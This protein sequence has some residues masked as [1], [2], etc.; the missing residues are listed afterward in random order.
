MIDSKATL[1]GLRIEIASLPPEYQV[2]ARYVEALHHE[3]SA[4][5]ADM[6]KVF[7]TGKGAL[8]A[9]KWLAAFGAAIAVIWGTI[10]GQRP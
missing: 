9:M 6:R 7:E 5:I 1:E 3:Q 8:S 10:H 2:L 4:Q